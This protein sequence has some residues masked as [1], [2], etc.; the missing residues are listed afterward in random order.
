MPAAPLDYAIQPF[1]GTDMVALVLGI[2]ALHC[3]TLRHRDSE[4]GMGWIA[5][6]LAGMGLTKC[7]RRWKKQD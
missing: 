2:A 3:L 6:G 4:P 1:S 5:A 7:A